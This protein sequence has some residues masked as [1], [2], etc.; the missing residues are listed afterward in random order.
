MARPLPRKPNGDIEEP[1]AS[2]LMVF[3]FKEPLTVK[4][5]V[6][7]AKGTVIVPLW[8]LRHKNF[9]ILNNNIQRILEYA[10]CHVFSIEVPLAIRSVFAKTYDLDIEDAVNVFNMMEFTPEEVSVPMNTPLT[11]SM[12]WIRQ[13]EGG[14]EDDPPIVKPIVFTGLGDHVWLTDSIDNIDFVV[15][16]YA[17][18]LTHDRLSLKGKSF[19][20]DQL[21]WIGSCDWKAQGLRFKIDKRSQKGTKHLKQSGTTRGK[22]E[23]GESSSKRRRKLASFE[24]IIDEASKASQVSTHQLSNDSNSIIASLPRSSSSSMGFSW[25]QSL[26]VSSSAQ[27]AV[28]PWEEEL[29]DDQRANDVIFIE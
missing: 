13:G 16:R 29:E 20:D 4:E 17:F 25:G 22:R 11:K 8:P 9:L 18:L 5:A 7:V 26:S 19:D 12:Q 15:Y 3:V 14:E 6:L 1:I 28:F 21:N 10:S 27:V 23:G 2:D 24:T